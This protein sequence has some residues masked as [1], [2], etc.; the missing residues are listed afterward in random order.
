M[1]AHNHCVAGGSNLC[2]IKFEFG[3]KLVL[4]EYLRCE[5]E[6]VSEINHH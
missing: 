6:L 5:H 1:V 3:I 4:M 2:V